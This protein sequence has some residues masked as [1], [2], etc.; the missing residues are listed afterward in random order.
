MRR[1]TNANPLFLVEFTKTLTE[2]FLHENDPKPS[3]Y[4]SME[5]NEPNEV[6]DWALY[7]VDFAFLQYTIIAPFGDTK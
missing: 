6:N 1:L 2:Q 3:I 7:L 4:V 5:L